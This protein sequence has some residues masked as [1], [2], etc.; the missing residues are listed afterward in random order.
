M[1]KDQIKIPG[2]GNY[3]PNFNTTRQNAPRFGFGTSNRVDKNP[4]VS[5]PGPGNYNH[6]QSVGTSAPKYS[7]TARNMYNGG[8]NSKNSIPGPGQYDSGKVNYTSQKAPTWRIGTSS[9]ED[10]L[11]KV[12]REAFPGPGNY[13]LK[14]DVNGPKFSF[15]HD[16]RMKN[17]SRLSTPGPG[18]YKV[19]TTIF[20]VPNFTN[21]TWDPNFKYV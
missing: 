3:D 14:N 10:G 18:Q 8:S 12:E 21:G 2:P 5:N 11:K 13:G 20:N 9:R 6:L 7:M 1:S 19:P 17:Q 4:Y 16:Q 15:G